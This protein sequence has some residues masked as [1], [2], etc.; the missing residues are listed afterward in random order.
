MSTASHDRNKVEPTSNSANSHNSN[1]PKM[2]SHSPGGEN[3]PF[4]DK[5][6]PKLG[7][8]LILKRNYKDLSGADSYVAASRNPGGESPSLPKDYE[9][10][11]TNLTDNSVRSEPSDLEMESLTS[12]DVSQ[13]TSQDSDQ[14]NSCESGGY[15]CAAGYTE[16]LENSGA[17][18]EA[19]D[20]GISGGDDTI[21]EGDLS[22]SE[23]IMAVD[24]LLHSDLDIDEHNESED[25][26]PIEIPDFFHDAPDPELENPR[27]TLCSELN[28]LNS[29]DDNLV[30]PYG[31]DSQ[32]SFSVDMP[33]IQCQSNTAIEGLLTNVPSN[34]MTDPLGLNNQDLNDPL[35][36]QATN[37]T[38][39]LGLNDTNG[40]LVDDGAS[41]SDM[42][43]EQTKPTEDFESALSSIASSTCADPSKPEAPVSVDS[44]LQSGGLDNSVEPMEPL[45]SLDYL[46]D[47][48]DVEEEDLGEQMQSAI[49]SILSLQQ[50]QGLAFRWPTTFA[51]T[52]ITQGGLLDSLEGLN[53]IVED[54]SSQNEDDL[55]AA[56]Q[57]IL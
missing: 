42:D 24:S 19:M 11:R 22:Q 29:S 1:I 44:G 51:S 47:I 49:D 27:A 45:E 39:P 35:G 41:G 34:K 15:V 43:A 16:D 18:E 25:E 9:D 12:A 2:D 57:S 48:S 5:D 46:S 55:D 8:K 21:T 38:D 31:D 26:D 14:E 23:D 36:L 6:K 52:H 40:A 32:S 50:L 56:I 54:D 3:I 4:V 33:D 17:K 10:F 28:V 7:V 30:S 13:V 37:L 20:T 53:Q